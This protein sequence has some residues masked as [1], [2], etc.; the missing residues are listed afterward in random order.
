MMKGPLLTHV[1][2]SS[3]DPRWEESI[4]TKSRL[5]PFLH[6]HPQPPPFVKCPRP[7]ALVF[8]TSHCHFTR[9]LCQ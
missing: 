1:E 4:D 8:T 5:I 7:V 3:S 2:K 6:S 9:A